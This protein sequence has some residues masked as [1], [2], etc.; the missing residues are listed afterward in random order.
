L[1]IEADLWETSAE[2]VE[3]APEETIL[4]K[5]AKDLLP[6]TSGNKDVNNQLKF[7][8]LQTA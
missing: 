5:V 2:L 8:K 4:S 7:P 3:L 6:Q 1:E